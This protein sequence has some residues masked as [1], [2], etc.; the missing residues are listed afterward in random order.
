[1][2]I[3]IKTNKDNAIKRVFEKNEVSHLTEFETDGS[4]F[5]FFSSVYEINQFLKIKKLFLVDGKIKSRL[6]LSLT[7][8]NIIDGLADEDFNGSFVETNLFVEDVTDQGLA[9][10]RHKYING[11]IVKLDDS[12]VVI[13]EEYK[14]LLRNEREHE[15]FRYVNR[16]SAWYNTLSEKQREELNVWYKKWLDVTETLRTP[17]RPDWLE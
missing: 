7:K 10:Y 9:D 8:D 1:M 3:Y 16:G 4:I 5:T 6:F 11:T 12:E 13:P 15:C 14:N 2:K 17:E